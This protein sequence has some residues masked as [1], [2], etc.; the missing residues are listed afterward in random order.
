MIYG[1]VLDTVADSGPKTLR[2]VS[3]ATSPDNLRLLANFFHEAA[4]ELESAKS[5][6]WHRHVPLHLSEAIGGDIIV[7]NPILETDGRAI[8]KPE[9]EQ[10]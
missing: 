3:I 9:G 6:H 2:E 8:R 1:H 10:L 7:L 5:Y 4:Q